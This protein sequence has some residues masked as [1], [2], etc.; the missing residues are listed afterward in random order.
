MVPLSCRDL[1][2]KC[3]RSV[4]MGAAFRH[5]RRGCGGQH[6]RS[7]KKKIRRWMVLRYCG[8]YGGMYSVQYCTPDCKTRTVH[9]VLYSRR[10][11]G[12]AAWLSSPGSATGFPTVQ[13]VRS[14][15]YWYSMYGTLKN[16]NKG[17]RS[18]PESGFLVRGLDSGSGRFSSICQMTCGLQYC[19]Y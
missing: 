9:T 18:G 6:M 8:L 3:D 12:A 14:T 17:S 5:W 19:S 2:G 15:P 11:Q 7:R 10:V 13:K 16:G 4:G 1:Q